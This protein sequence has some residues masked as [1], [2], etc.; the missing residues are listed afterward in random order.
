MNAVRAESYGTRP[1]KPNADAVDANELFYGFEVI[2]PGTNGVYPA[3]QIECLVRGNAALCELHGWSAKSVIQHGEGTHRKPDMSWQGGPSKSGPAVRAE[4][5]RALREG[6]DR[7]TYPASEPKPPEDDDMAMTAKDQAAL[8]EAVRKAV[9]TSATVAWPADREAAGSG[10]AGEGHA[11]AVDP[12]PGRRRRPRQGRRRP[13]CRA[14]QGHH[15]RPGK[16][17]ADVKAAARAGAADAL[18]DSVVVSGDV[19][20]TPTASP[21]EA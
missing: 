11:A 7:Y 3:A 6:P 13:S 4:V 18:K 16:L 19:T 17:A 20:V 14:G 10:R 12:R 15:V 5:A 8:V 9:W 1:P 21:S 2:H